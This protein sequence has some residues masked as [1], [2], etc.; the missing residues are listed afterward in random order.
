M[1]AYRCEAKTKIGTRCK[2][3]AT[4]THRANGFEF[5][6]CKRHQASARHGV[7]VAPA[8]TISD[9]PPPLDG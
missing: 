6:I 8:V 7:P 9:C 5:L 3:E 2:C 4:T 1:A